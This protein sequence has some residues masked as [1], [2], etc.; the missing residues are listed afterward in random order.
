MPILVVWIRSFF[1]RFESLWEIHKD[2]LFRTSSELN[3]MST[4]KALVTRPGPEANLSF[5]LEIKTDLIYTPLAKFSLSVTIF[6]Q[7]WMP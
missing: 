5:F 2:L 7:W 4:L 6:K 1:S 3:E